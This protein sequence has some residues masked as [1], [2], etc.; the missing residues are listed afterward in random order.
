MFF[1][2]CNA[3][4]FVE[5]L[6]KLMHD[7]PGPVYLILENVSFHKAPP[8]KEYVASLEGRLKLFFLPGYSPE[9]NPDERVGRMGS[10][11]TSSGAGIQR[12]SEL[13]GIAT[14]ALERL[15]RLPEVI[16]G[17]FRDPALAYIGM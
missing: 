15:Q 14:R 16:R 9:L 4:V 8:V 3:T 1:G 17:F 13:F 12:G 6:K 11:T 5:F 7:A 10:T 2:S